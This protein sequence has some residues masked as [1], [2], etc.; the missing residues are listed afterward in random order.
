M[1]KLPNFLCVGAG[2][3]GTTSLYHYLKQHPEVF[4][5]AQKEL[6]FFAWKDL[7]DLNGGPGTAHSRSDWCK[8]LSQY[9]KMFEGAADYKVVGDIS[10]SYLHAPSAASQIAATLG[11]PK[12]VILLRNPIDKV[13][14]Q[15]MHLR[16]DGREILDL[17]GALAAE[18]ERIASKWGA[19]Y[20]YVAT[21][22]YDQDVARYQD[23]F[24]VE[25]VRIWSFKKF[26]QQSEATMTEI[27][28]FL[29]ID[30]EFKFAPPEKTNRSG[31]PRSRTVGRLIGPNGLTSVAKKITP[32][33]LGVKI[34][35]KV[36][37][38]N[39][40]KKEEISDDELFYLR[41]IFAEDIATLEQ[42]TGVDLS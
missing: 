28:A 6:H 1:T 41:E 18:P 23:A 34:K 26:V 10:P 29:E 40:G 31:K 16:R 3:S 25:N 5:P 9:S 17:R 7:A 4:L 33:P 24:G 35:A 19:M 30:P 36:L 2:K 39:T 37:E 22:K 12:I 11:K 32:R 21:S 14:S 20:H 15:Y 27:C 42:R 38:L 13:I 8:N